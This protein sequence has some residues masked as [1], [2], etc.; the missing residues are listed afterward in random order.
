MKP[1]PAGH[2]TLTVFTKD[3]QHGN[4][5]L[6]NLAVDDDAAEV[7]RRIEKQT[8]DRAKATRARVQTER[9]LDRS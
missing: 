8:K 1:I 2:Q 4:T 7:V 3:P 9:D 5:I 6:V